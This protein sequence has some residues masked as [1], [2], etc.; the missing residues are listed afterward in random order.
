MLMCRHL[1]PKY[2]FLSLFVSSFAYADLCN[3]AWL[4]SVERK[5]VGVFLEDKNESDVQRVCEYGDTPLHLALMI[6]A[7]FAVIRALIE[8]GADLFAVN[9]ARQIPFAIIDERYRF[10]LIAKNEAEEQHKSKII[11]MRELSRIRR[12]YEE[13]LMI[14]RYL[15]GLMDAT[16]KPY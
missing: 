12:Q 4:G 11:N 7:R 2:V 13:T 8:K 1:V 14:H 9:T 15:K 5:E 3:P 16:G 6:Q 10:D